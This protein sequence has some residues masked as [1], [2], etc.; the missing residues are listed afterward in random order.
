MG[1]IHM[2]QPWEP[3]GQ[4]AEHIINK[5]LGFMSKAMGCKEVWIGMDGLKKVGGGCKM[6]SEI[7][8]MTYR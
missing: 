2:A 8:T 5:N 7:I 6:E 4:C 1:K 3:R